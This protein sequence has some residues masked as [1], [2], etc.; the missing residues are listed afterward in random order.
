MP[1][2]EFGD[3]I[4]MSRLCAHFYSDLELV[5][6]KTCLTAVDLRI[7]DKFESLKLTKS[8]RNSQEH[9]INRF[10]ADRLAFLIAD[11]FY[12]SFNPNE[13][14]SIAA[15]KL[16]LTSKQILR[17]CCPESFNQLL[18]VWGNFFKNDSDI[19]KVRRPLF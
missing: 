11:L 7:A 5:L 17:I 12:N 16:K 2:C 14:L 1:R 15:R 19:T 3:K 13:Q 4:S 9:F 6:Q 18:I 8:G 10:Q